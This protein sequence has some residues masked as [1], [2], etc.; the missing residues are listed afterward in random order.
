M[1]W[2]SR[3][4]IKGL[5]GVCRACFD[6]DPAKTSAKACV[7]IW[8]TS[9]WNHC[10]DTCWQ[11]WESVLSTDCFYNISAFTAMTSMHSLSI[12]SWLKLETHTTCNICNTLDKF[13][14]PMPCATDGTSKNTLYHILWKK[15][16]NFRNS[17]TEEEGSRKN[18]SHG[19]WTT[20]VLVESIRTW[21]E[22]KGRLWVPSQYTPSYL[23][24]SVETHQTK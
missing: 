6:W 4:D 3:L 20:T 9:T 1:V 11:I 22:K 24:W 10:A 12:T 15:W 19:Q 13:D 5:W 23:L 7:S 18:R 16:S 14:Y 21:S 2:L 8:Y 17:I